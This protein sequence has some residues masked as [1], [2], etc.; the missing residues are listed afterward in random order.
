MFS[1]LAGFLDPGE[2]LEQAAEREVREE[3]GIQIAD[4]E[5]VASQPWSFPNSLMLGFRARYVSGEIT[6]DGK[7]IEE[8]H[9]FKRSAL[10]DI[11][12]R[13]TVARDLIDRWLAS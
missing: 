10:P 7:E 8:A 12:R 13:G 6:V 11:P 4:I 5:Y 1:V 3:V 2:T 9:W